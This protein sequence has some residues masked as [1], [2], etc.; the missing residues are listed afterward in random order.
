MLA[1]P[2]RLSQ[3]EEISQTQRSKFFSQSGNF[4]VTVSK[5][6]NDKSRAC[7]IV[8]KKVFKKSHDRHRIKRKVMAVVEARFK[9]EES[10]RR[11]ITILCRSKT[12]LQLKSADL[13]LEI[14][15]MINDALQKMQNYFKNKYKDQVQT[16]SFSPSKDIIP[17]RISS[18]VEQ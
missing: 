13:E 15:Q 6:K 9:M 17:S 1:R 16:K 18:S 10:H 14:N 3:Q 11:N 2:Y 4:K 7:F 5:S 8:G 12:S